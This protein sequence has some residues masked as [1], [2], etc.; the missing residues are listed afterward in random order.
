MGIVT[1]TLVVIAVAALLA[2]GVMK[3]ISKDDADCC[4]CVL[5]FVWDDA[6]Y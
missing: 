1:V 2:F 3:Q 6:D 5:C 4:E